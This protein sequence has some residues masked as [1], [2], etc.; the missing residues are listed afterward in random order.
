MLVEVPAP[1]CEGI[2]DDV[3]VEPPVDHFPA[4]RLDGGE[5]GLVPAAQFM[6]GPRGGQLHRAEGMD[7]PAMDG[8]AGQGKILHRPQRV[9]APE[10][11][12]RH[13]AAAQQVG[14][15]AECRPSTWTQGSG[16]GGQG[17]G[18]GRSR[19]SH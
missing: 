3:L 13:V 4:G 8:P 7:Q 10:R 16:A 2:D 1:P 11:V 5:L 12:G 19:S 14:F 18:A 15:A 9:D 17:P 6:V